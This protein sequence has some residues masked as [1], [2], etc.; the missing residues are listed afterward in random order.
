MAAG[1]IAPAILA[2]TI[3]G[4]TMAQSVE[5][6]LAELKW[7]K[8]VVGMLAEAPGDPALVEQERRLAA[9]AMGLAARDLVLI[10]ASDGAVTIDGEP[11][12]APTEA[13]LR[14][15]LGAGDGFQV[16]LIGKDG[17]VKLRAE[18]PVAAHEIF[19]LIDSMP[20]RQREI[21]ERGR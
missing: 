3:G 19:A 17:G 16:L 8:R 20:M 13:A 9:E 4:T 7:Q 18:E 1:L 10:A 12:D 21:R 15:S 5:R 6:P 11:R 2:A 14:R